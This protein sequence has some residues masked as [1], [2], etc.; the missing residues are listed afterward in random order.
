MPSFARPLTPSL[1]SRRSGPPAAGLALFGVVLA[2][3]ALRFATLSQQS[4]W[5]DEA[6]TVDLLHR[7]FADLWHTLPV[8]ESTPPAYYV[9]AW[10]W[11]RVWGLSE[12]G[13]RSL[14]AVAGLGTVLLSYAAASR[15]L[16]R[17]VGLIAGT[18]VACSPLMIWF[19][20]EARAY[21]LASCL[22]AGAFLCLVGYLD[23]GRSRWLA[24]WALS[25]ALGLATHYFLVFVVAPE[26]L[27]LLLRGRRDPGCRA[28]IAGVVAAGGALVPLALS[29]LATGHADYISQGGLGQR[30]VQVPKQLLIGYASPL[31]QLTGVLSALLVLA[32][33]LPLVHHRARLGDRLLLPLTVGFG[34]VLI[35]V[36]LAFV[37]IDF[38]NT[39]NLLPALPLLLIVLAI[40]LSITAPAR[41]GKLLA[42]GLGAVFLAVVG[43]VDLDPHYQRADWRAAAAALGSSS[44]ARLIVVVP[45]SGVLPL[46]IY[47][48]DLTSQTAATAVSELD[49]VAIGLQVTGSGIGTP[50]RLRAPL[51]VPSG[52]RLYRAVYGTTFTVL[53][54]RAAAPAKLGVPSLATFALEP[55]RLAV[56]RQ[57]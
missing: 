30:L 25:S 9:L 50:P 23:T 36:A 55:G 28:A 5:L 8:T 44:T 12:P 29:Q 13:L 33:L 35:P 41:A 45:G 38:V 15:L 10:I 42:V 43:L 51:P 53:R 19:S 17:R 20:Q 31:Q 3:V 39:R 46:R 26:I 54:Y 21:A 24:G 27:W 14:S 22:A 56:L 47:E 18:L 16:D 6:Y 37:G 40:G 34:A 57:P 1:A 2:A 32:G 7:S 49:V 11:T 4:F 52:F 48:P